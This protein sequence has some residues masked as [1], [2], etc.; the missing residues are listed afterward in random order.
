MRKG[1]INVIEIE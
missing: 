1:D